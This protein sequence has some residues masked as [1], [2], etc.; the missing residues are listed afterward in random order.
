M[1]KEGA[2]GTKKSTLCVFTSSL[3]A[4]TASSGADATAPSSQTLK[5][6]TRNFT[7]TEPPH[8]PSSN[9]RIYPPC[10]LAVTAQDCVVRH[11][12]AA[13]TSRREHGPRGVPPR[14]AADRLWRPPSRVFR[15][16]ACFSRFRAH[17]TRPSVCGVAGFDI[18]PCPTHPGASAGRV[19]GSSAA[20]EAACGGRKV[21]I[22]H[23]LCTE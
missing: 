18:G 5:Q 20:G 17:R 13:K 4:R 21:V 14:R 19:A 9:L 15:V 2:C 6:R 8:P 16:F 11:R 3:R 10:V 23:D 1:V 22:F 7:P 12:G